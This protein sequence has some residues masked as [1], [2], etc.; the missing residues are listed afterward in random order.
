MMDADWLSTEISKLLVSPHISFPKPPAGIRL[1]PGPVDL[2]STN[3]NNLF[4]PDVV[5]T[6]DGEKVS[7]DELKQKLLNLQKH[8]ESDKVRLQ[9]EP[10][11]GT[12]SPCG[13][14]RSQEV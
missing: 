6:V 1:G 12:V 14:E 4:A 11:R 3:F 5:A 13:F 10:P 2:F 9:E 8:W 7:R